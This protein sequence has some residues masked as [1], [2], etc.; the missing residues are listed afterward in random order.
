MKKNTKL[1]FFMSNCNVILFRQQKPVKELFYYQF[2]F[3][4]LFLTHLWQFIF[5]F[6]PETS[7]S[8]APN[9]DGLSHAWLFELS[10]DW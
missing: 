1:Y 2:Q 10:T 8:L 4:T 9:R 6:P 7:A 3:S 5:S